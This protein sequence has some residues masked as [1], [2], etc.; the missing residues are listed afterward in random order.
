MRLCRLTRSHRGVFFL[1]GST[2]PGSSLRNAHNS[3][4]CSSLEQV[5][6][7]PVRRRRPSFLTPLTRDISG[8]IKLSSHGRSFRESSFG[9]FGRHYEEQPAL[10]GHNHPVTGSQIINHVPLFTFGRK[11]SCAITPWVEMI[12]YTIHTRRAYSLLLAPTATTKVMYYC[13]TW[14][15][16]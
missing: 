6:L 9:S 3:R 13:R 1:W 14:S 12:G 10:G 15:K 4:S 8:R 11:C 16:R 7:S 5:F 2:S